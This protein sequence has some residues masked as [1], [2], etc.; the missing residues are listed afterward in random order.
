MPR[1][2]RAPE[3][4][5]CPNSRCDF[6]DDPRR[7]RFKKKG[8]FRRQRGPRRVQ[9]YQCQHCGRSFSSQ[10]F[11]TTYWLK[12]PELI[13]PVFWRLLG[14]S[15]LRQIAREFT[16]SPSTIQ[17]HAERLG[18]HCQLLHEVFRP[19]GAPR[20]PLVLDGFRSFEFGQY[21]PF[22]LNLLV[23]A[24]HYVYAMNEAE[25]RRSGTHTVR[26]K[27]RRAELEARFGR[28]DARATRR[29]VAELVS[30][31][32]PPGASAVIHSDEHQ[33]YPRALAGLSDRSIRHER[34]S[35]RVPRTSRNPLFPVNLA[36][37]LLRHGGGNHKRETIAFSKRR[38]G[39][40]YR[41][42]VWLVWR[43]YMK[44]TSERRRDDPP[45]VRLGVITRRLSLREALAVRLFP[46]RTALRGWPARC[47]YAR[48]HTRTIPSASHHT[49]RYAC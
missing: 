40:V 48:I 29:A 20:E 1:R 16:A 42:W 9:R 12:R 33:E 10:T 43:N 24:S 26:Q 8:F 38:Q 34:T 21:W 27:A 6:H 45:A 25:L 47:Y 31:V 28:P 32:V 14:C 4:P 17:R 36:D 18:R 11:S 22:D 15:A 39:A 46:T 41:A 23:G 3:P 30:R 49:L 35:S 2:P 13:E 37:L 7:W 44:S 5:F 19:K